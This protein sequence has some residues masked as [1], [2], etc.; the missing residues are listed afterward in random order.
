MTT[1]IDTPAEAEHWLPDE[2]QLADAL[3]QVVAHRLEHAVATRGQALL[4]VSGGKSP[5]ALFRALSVQPGL[6]T[7]W[8]MVTVLPVDERCVPTDHADSNA[9]LIRTHLL[10]GAAT[11]ARWVPLVADDAP[12]DPSA[13]PPADPPAAAPVEVPAEVPLVVPDVDHLQQLAESR[14]ADLPW[15]LDV[16]VLGMGL[17]GHTASFFP[18]APGL[19]QALSTHGHCAWVRPDAQRNQAQHARLTLS[20]STLMAAQHIYLPLAGA[21]KHAVYQQARQTPTDQLPVSL[22]LHRR[23]QPVSVWLSP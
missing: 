20:L 22:L 13:Y 1:P 15:P 21:A 2:Q 16:A 10:Q 17:D 23:E 19:E 14:L 11:A 5:V 6:A 18:G 9:R 12:I 7:L 4:A 8:P 3:A